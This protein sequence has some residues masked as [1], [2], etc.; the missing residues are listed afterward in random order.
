MPQDGSVSEREILVRVEHP[1]A[2]AAVFRDG[3]GRWLTGDLE[4]GGG[5]GLRDDGGPSV[6]ARPASS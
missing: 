4:R 5:T 1:D 2:V 3:S 6:G